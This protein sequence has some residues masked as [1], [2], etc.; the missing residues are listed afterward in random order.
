VIIEK[1]QKNNDYNYVKIDDFVSVA[2][3]VK[4]RQCT[5]TECVTT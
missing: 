4:N 3:N 5:E 1:Q 2:D